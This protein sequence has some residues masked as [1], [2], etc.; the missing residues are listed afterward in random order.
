MKLS[1]K[2]KKEVKFKSRDDFE[3][4]YKSGVHSYISEIEK[5]EKQIKELKN[6]WISVTEHLP[7][8]KNGYIYELVL[9]CVKNKN[10]EDGIYL[11]DVSSF[12]GEVWTKRENTWENVLYWMPIPEKSKEQE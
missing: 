12:D 1:E 9:V 10:K 11:Y 3:S 7:S 5:L 8:T 6:T 2:M 4:G